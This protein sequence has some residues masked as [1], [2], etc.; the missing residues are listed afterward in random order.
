MA[1]PAP[2]GPRRRAARGSG[3]IRERSPGVF[4]VRVVVG[5]DPRTGRSVQRS[6]TVRGDTEHAEARRREL[7]ADYGIDLTMLHASGLTVGE[8]LT[9]WYAAGHAWKPSTR[10]GY[11]SDVR[12]VCAD[13][14]AS[15]RLCSLDTAAMSRVTSRWQATGVTLA[16]VS[17]RTKALS[18]AL[19]W[20]VEQGILRSHP[21]AGMRHPPVPLPRLPMPLDDVDRLLRASRKL[22]AEA[23]AEG[24]SLRVFEAE[25]TELLVRLAADSGARRGELAAL[26]VNDL[27]GRVL[28]ICRNISGP[29]TVTTPKSHQYRSLTLG[30][31]TVELWRAHLERWPAGGAGRDWL[32]SPS[33]TRA[34]FVQPRGLAARFER[35]R[36]FAGVPDACLHRLR[37]TVA[38]V[39]VAE[40]KLLAA[41]HRLGHRDLSTTLRHYGWA[42]APDDTEV[43]DDLDA[44]LNRGRHR[45]W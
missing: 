10:I 40:G 16:T 23:R 13:P 39:L 32:F 28:H 7:V 30:A 3:S 8:L 25:Q 38:V 2:A 19:R 26:K 17:T 21:L 34:T 20:A 43:A 14:I 42:Q 35:V 9:R 41:Q 33:P 4:E 24:C 29:R 15:L 22:V 45:S 18:S 11:D 1:D 44:V 37:H 5:R 36:D 12:A 31:T 27:D 6:F